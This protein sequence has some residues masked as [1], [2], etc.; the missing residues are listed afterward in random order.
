MRRT[1][2]HPVDPDNLDS[3]IDDIQTGDVAS[4]GGKLQPA[5]SKAQLA[6]TS[7]VAR[8][9]SGGVAIEKFPIEAQRDLKAYDRAEDGVID[10]QDVARAF[11]ALRGLE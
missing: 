3:I 4:E 11:Q 10:G 8:L 5:P 2:I 6:Y 9:A 7:S 1:T